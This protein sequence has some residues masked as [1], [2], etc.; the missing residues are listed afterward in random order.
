MRMKNS[1]TISKKKSLNLKTCY[2]LQQRNK[3]Y[4]LLMNQLFKSQ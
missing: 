1:N 2:M 3:N 4:Y